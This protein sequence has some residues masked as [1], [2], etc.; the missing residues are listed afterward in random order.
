MKISTRKMTIVA[1]MAAI[2]VILVYLIHTPLIPGLAFLEYDPADIPIFI[3]TFMFG[4]VAGLILTVV[5][6]VIQGLTVSA[7]SGIIGIVMHIVATGSFVILAG[8]L[9]K[10]MPSIKGA[11]L[12]LGAG[13]LLWI[14][15]MALW[16]L[17]LTP[18]FMGIPREVLLSQYY[19]GIVL[20]NVIKAGINSVCTFLLYKVLG[21]FI[22]K[23]VRVF[24]K[25]ER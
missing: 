3:T 12:S 14:A 6:S 17:V 4:P 1:M 25:T 11:A 20:F 24:A 19:G 10:R 18:I 22:Q 13:V 2:S 8:N 7:G 16:N 15:V 9:Y 21:P 23:Q 5:V